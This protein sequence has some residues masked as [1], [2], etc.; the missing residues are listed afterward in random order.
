MASCNKISCDNCKK[1]YNSQ[2][3]YQLFET[4]LCGHELCKSCFEQIIK[5]K[6][7][8]CPYCNKPFYPVL[9]NQSFRQ[10]RVKYN[11]NMNEKNN[12]C[13][14]APVEE[15]EGPFGLFDIEILPNTL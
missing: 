13:N 10:Y 6:K 11:E 3:T 9:K 4:L 8:T 2:Y 7:Y 14:S 5:T 1:S 15:F 12:L